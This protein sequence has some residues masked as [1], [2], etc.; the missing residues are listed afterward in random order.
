MRFYSPRLYLKD[1][2]VWVPLVVSLFCSGFLFV[3]LLSLGAPSVGQTFLH[4]NVIF[5]VDRAGEWSQLYRYPII[6]LVGILVNFSIAF[7][8]Y[9]EY[10]PLSRLLTLF[11]PVGAGLITISA[12]FII[13]LNV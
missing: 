5:G 6:S 13:N 7:L 2:L 3:R 9:S 1:R 12:A 8:L 10:R 11:T 4:Y